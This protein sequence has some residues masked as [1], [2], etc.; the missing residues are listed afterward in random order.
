MT[1]TRKHLSKSEADS[2][3]AKASMAL[4]SG[5]PHLSNHLQVEMMK[6]ELLRAPARQ[7]R[8]HGESHLSKMVA[9]IKRFG[10]IVPVLIAP[11]NELITGVARVEA[12]RRLALKFVPVIRV[13]TLSTEEVRA[14]RIADNR[15][16]ELAEWD[17]HQLAL[18]FKELLE[19]NLDFSLE[20]TAFN[21]A[22]IDLRLDALSELKP[23]ADPADEHPPRPAAPTSQTGDLWRLGDHRL[24]CGN[25]LE[26]SV[27]ALLMESRLARLLM[28]DPPWNVPIEGH[29]SGLGRHHHRP[30]AMAT[31]EMSQEQFTDFLTSVLQQVR[32]N[33][34]PDGLASVF[35]D[36]RHTHEL[37]TAQRRAGFDLINLCVW[38]KSNGGMGSLY[39]S[40]HELAFL[41]GNRKAGHVNNVQLGKFGRYR[42]NVWEY[43]GVN[44]FG[45]TRDQDL[46]DHPT[47]KPTLL[48]A[49]AIRDVTHRGDL[50]L[51]PFVGSGTTI[52]AA[53]RTGRKARAIEIDPGYVDVAIARW[54]K[55]TGKPAVLASTGQ[56][57]DEVRC[58]RAS[59]PSAHAF[60]QREGGV[61]IRPRSRAAMPPATVSEER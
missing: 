24:V 33:L 20:L 58:Q 23:G 3:T 43:A 54:S 28:T 8:R 59:D 45:K 50:V 56:T 55:L 27:Y 25:A 44:A 7:L 35:M 21:T 1:N 48:V 31:G 34:M 37:T 53:E 60:V 10:F 18:E 12:A 40:R 13:N 42:C 26:A 41:M 22:E 47:V 5:I 46:T 14:F 29:V 51:D 19:L 16:A 61:R 4:A 36:W 52:L 6:L 57:F 30:F 39:R 11:D 38:V 17:E 49:D 9:C 32:K 2:P 15:L